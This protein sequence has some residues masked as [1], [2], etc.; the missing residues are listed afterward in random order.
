V[1]PSGTAPVDTNVSPGV[2]LQGV[3]CIVS[4]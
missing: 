4:V 2:E 3:F 1:T